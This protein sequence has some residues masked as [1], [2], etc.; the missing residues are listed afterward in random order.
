MYFRHELLFDRVRD[1]RHEP[2]FDRV[3]VSTCTHI[4]LMSVM[5]WIQTAFYMQKV[6]V[7]VSTHL[8]TS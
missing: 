1:F 5:V 6:V 2:L 4:L 3:S 8:V 7:C